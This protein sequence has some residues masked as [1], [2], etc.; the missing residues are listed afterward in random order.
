MPP[1]LPSPWA[2]RSSGDLVW[3][4]PSSAEKMYIVHLILVELG[5]VAHFT[6]IEVLQHEAHL[7]F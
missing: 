2:P 4:T 6:R 3:V 5:Q 1:S 7:V